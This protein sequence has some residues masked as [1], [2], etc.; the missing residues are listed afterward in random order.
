LKNWRKL[1]EISESHMHPKKKLPLPSF[2]SAKKE[3]EFWE[4]HSALDYDL[5]FSTEQFD[6][7][8]NAGSI[9]LNIRLPGWLVN[10]IKAYAQEDGLSHQRFIREVLI[11]H[12]EKCG[13]QKIKRH[14]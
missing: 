7:H 13:K 8:P 5:N 1:A 3:A 11:A 12:V 9:S 6:I 14:E 2:T 4:N 10:E